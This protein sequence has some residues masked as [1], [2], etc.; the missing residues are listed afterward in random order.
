MAFDMVGRASEP[1]ATFAEL[2]SLR[3]RGRL[4][5]IGSMRTPLPLLYMD[6]IANI[7]EII[8]NF[9]YPIDSYRLLL[10][11]VRAG[12][13]DIGAIRPRTVPAECTAGSNG[14]SGHS[15]Q[16]RMRCG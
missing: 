9:M 4:V 15:G 14:C 13:P 1:N 3:R 8:G 10:D 7:W 11:L 16:P 6:L 12:L 5:L 2:H